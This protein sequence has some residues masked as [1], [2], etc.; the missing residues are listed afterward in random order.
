MDCATRTENKGETGK[1]FKNRKEEKSSE[2]SM[3]ETLRKK[4]WDMSVLY[5]HLQDRALPPP[6]LT[7]PKKTRVRISVT[8]S[9]EDDDSEGDQPKSF[10]PG[11]LKA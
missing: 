2:E 10:N 5:C 4:V 6:A 1:F 7:L 3:D 9:P 8:P 11:K